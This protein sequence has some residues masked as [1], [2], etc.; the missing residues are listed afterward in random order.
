M[1]DSVAGTQAVDRALSILQAFDDQT[2]ELGV[3][4]VASR[5]GVHRSTPGL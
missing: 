2:P 3:A 5:L 4:D 1:S